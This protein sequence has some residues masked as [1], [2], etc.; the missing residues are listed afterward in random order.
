M[1]KRDTIPKPGGLGVDLLG[2]PVRG[3]LCSGVVRALSDFCS[4]SV[5]AILN[6]DSLRQA[7]FMDRKFEDILDTLPEKPPRSRLEP[8][9]E[10]IGELRKRGRTYRDIAGI[11]A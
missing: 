2:V 1:G 3:T 5:W 8:Y 7:G 11:L 10:L 6:A 4:A 9:R